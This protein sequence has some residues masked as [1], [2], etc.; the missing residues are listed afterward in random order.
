[1]KHSVTLDLQ[2]NGYANRYDLQYYAAYDRDG[3]QI[4]DL[5]VKHVHNLWPATKD[6]NRIVV[7]V[8]A[9][10]HG[11]S[12]QINAKISRN[13]L[14]WS[15]RGL[16]MEGLDHLAGEWLTQRFP[17]LDDEKIHK[18]FVSAIPE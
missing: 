3:H 18:I 16:P 4:L 6:A 15:A 7:K 11:G 12:K 5:C 17:F 14:Y 2:Y 9:T 13:S 10:R 8:S 1:M